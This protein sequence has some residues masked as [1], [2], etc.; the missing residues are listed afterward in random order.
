M[1]EH[2]AK[3]ELVEVGDDARGD[4]AVCVGECGRKIVLDVLLCLRRHIAQ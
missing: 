2:D 1:R 3:T 4:R